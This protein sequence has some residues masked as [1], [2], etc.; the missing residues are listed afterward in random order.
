MDFEKLQVEEYRSDYI[1]DFAQ[2]L[3]DPI[4]SDCVLNIKDSNIKL[5]CHR[6]ILANASEFFFNAFTS[7]M[8]E[9]QKGE[10]EITFNPLNLFP[11]VVFFL[12]TSFIDLN[13]TNIMAFYEFA[14]FYGIQVLLN[15]INQTIQEQGPANIMK[16]VK[17]CYANEFDKA[18]SLLVPFLAQFFENISIGEFSANLDIKTFCAVVE[19]AARLKTFTGDVVK[20]L[21][22]FLNGAKPDQQEDLELRNLISQFAPS[23]TLPAWL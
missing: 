22:Q 14:H 21:N 18:L 17:S 16:Y 6:I 2:F 19:Q 4:I 9:E 13:D 15:S 3:N 1:F 7:G 12:Y 20:V 8:L 5:K 23:P 10:V 11:G